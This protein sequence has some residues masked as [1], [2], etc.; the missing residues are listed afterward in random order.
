MQQDFEINRGRVQTLRAA[1]G[2]PSAFEEK[3]SPD[4]VRLDEGHSLI[5]RLPGL[6]GDGE[7][8]ILAGSSTECTRAAVEYVTRPEYVAAFVRRMHEKGLIPWWFQVV[9]RARF[10]SQTPIAIEMAA[11]HALK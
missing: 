2:E 8:L 3:W 9:I 11:F 5:S 6:H 4:H 7:M 1:P 10:K